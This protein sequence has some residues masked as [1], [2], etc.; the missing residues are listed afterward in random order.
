MKLPKTPVPPEPERYYVSFRRATERH[1]HMIPIPL[2]PEQAERLIESLEQI[3]STCWLEDAKTVENRRNK[4]M[5]A[6]AGT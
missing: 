2:T 5:K 3:G 1:A 6:F 4:S